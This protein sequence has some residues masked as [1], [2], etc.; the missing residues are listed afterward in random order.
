MNNPESLKKQ[1]IDA[2]SGRLGLGVAE[3]VFNHDLWPV[4]EAAM[5]AGE[6]LVSRNTQ[7]QIPVAAAIKGWL[8]G[9][10]TV[11]AR[12]RE[13]EH[14]VS[15]RQLL[16]VLFELDAVAQQALKDSETISLH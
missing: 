6:L 12:I 9:C 16:R 11:M 8:E 5:K 13:D 3:S 1:L 2:M 4:L 10:V 7:E 14:T 15:K